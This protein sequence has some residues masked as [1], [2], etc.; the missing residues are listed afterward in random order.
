MK[1]SIFYKE[2][3]ETKIMTKEN[4][5]NLI[6]VHNILYRSPVNGASVV[7]MAHVLVT[8]QKIIQEEANDLAETVSPDESKEG[9]EQQ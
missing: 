8:L 6:E 2:S 4:L 3:K 7:P 9:N 1:E 5:Q